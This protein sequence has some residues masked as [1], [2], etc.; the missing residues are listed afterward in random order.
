VISPETRKR[1]KGEKVNKC[2]QTTERL[3]STFT[4]FKDATGSL[5]TL[6]SRYGPLKRF[7][8]GMKLLAL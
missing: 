5:K 6:K 4:E 2:G 1:V 8:S 3:L 7:K